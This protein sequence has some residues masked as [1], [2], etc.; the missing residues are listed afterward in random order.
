MCDARA[1]T[2]SVIEG[3][4]K[5][6]ITAA[7]DSVRRLRNGSQRPKCFNRPS[8]C[9]QILRHNASVPSKMRSVSEPF[10]QSFRDSVHFTLEVTYLPER[11][12]RRTGPGPTPDLRSQSVGPSIDQSDKPRHCC[13]PDCSPAAIFQSDRTRHSAASCLGLRRTVLESGAPY[14]LGP[15]TPRH[16]HSR[17]WWH[18]ETFHLEA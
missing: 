17:G 7:I 1:S 9:S 15:K 4:A 12:A 6:A 18:R 10:P 14:P 3:R 16:C 13:C 8:T 5:L 2:R 11:I